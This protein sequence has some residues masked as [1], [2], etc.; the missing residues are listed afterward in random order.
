MQ[1]FGSEIGVVA[2]APRSDSFSGRASGTF[3]PGVSALRQPAGGPVG[4][5][6]CSSGAKLSGNVTPKP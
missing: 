1:N 3:Q 4:L 6:S 5:W 2:H